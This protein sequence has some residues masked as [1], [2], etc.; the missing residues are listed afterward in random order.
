VTDVSGVVSGS[1]GFTDDTALV[2]RIVAG[3]DEAIAAAYDRHAPAVY[4]AAFRLVGERTIAEDVVQETFLALWNRAE[5]F[6]AERGSLATWLTTIARHRAVDRLRAAGRRPRTVAIG[7]RG[8]AADGADADADALE[9]LLASAGTPTATS[10]PEAAYA[11]VELRETLARALATMSDPERE[12]IALAYRDELTQSE[13]AARLGWPLGTVK[14]RTRRALR[15]LRS[16]LAEIAPDLA[17]ELA[18]RAEVL[19]GDA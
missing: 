13:I 2:G 3:S 9:R 7:G 11:A 14:T 16:A 1:A 12:V 18:P 6:D 19:D 10:D 8:S 4:A 5:T 17:P 15:R